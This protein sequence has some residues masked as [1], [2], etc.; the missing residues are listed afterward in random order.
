MKANTNTTNT[1]S[2]TIESSVQTNGNHKASS[3]NYTGETDTSVIEPSAATGRPESHLSV[4]ARQRGLNIK[5]LAVLMDV[6]PSHLS[7]VARGKK[8]LTPFMRGKIEAV[9][10]WVPPQGVVH[11]QGGV[12]K[13]GES[14]YLRERA[15]ERGM[16]LRQVADRTGLT[17]GYVVQVSR[18][19]RNLSPSA[20]A[21]ME[22]VLEAPVKIEAAQCPTI[23]PN[24]LWERMDAHGWSQ[25]ETA[26]RAGISTGMFSQVMNGRRTPSGDLLRRL[27]EVLFAPSPAELIAPV[28]LKVMAWKKGG[29]NGMVIKGAGGPRS[30]GKPGDGTIRVGGRVPWGAE[31]EFA[32]TSGYDRHGRVS[33]N[34]VVDER[35][36]SAML[37]KAEATK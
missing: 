28:E 18:G 25:N 35:G 33:V 34:H 32:Y 2:Y 29:R 21:R 8:T 7:Q 19:Q 17:Y 27:H 24:A 36:C 4:A 10:G 3:V 1:V 12:V 31:V 14:T 16:T 26:R 13:G 9:L 5:E 30:G 22:S 15:R 37:K 11:R 23:D 20:Q 6:G